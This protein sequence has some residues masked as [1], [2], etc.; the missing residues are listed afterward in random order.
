MAPALLLTDLVLLLTNLLTFWL[1]LLV[2]VMITTMVMVV[3]VLLQCGV[4]LSCICG[5]WSILFMV[6]KDVLML[7]RQRQLHPGL[8]FS[9]NFL[10][11]LE[12]RC[13]SLQ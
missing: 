12:L 5:I 2:L 6:K 10:A 4:C 9:V 11:L 1:L 3:I 7:C 13:M 8:E